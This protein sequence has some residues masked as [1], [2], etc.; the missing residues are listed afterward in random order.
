MLWFYKWRHKI[1]SENSRDQRLT[2]R[3][4]YVSHTPQWRWTNVTRYNDYGQIFTRTN[5][6]FPLLFLFQYYRLLLDYILGKKRYYFFLL[7]NWFS[8][9][10][11][12]WYSK[13]ENRI[14][15]ADSSLS[16][17]FDKIWVLNNYFSLQ[18]DYRSNS[19]FVLRFRLCTQFSIVEA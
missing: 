9:F 3:N 19:V 14:V 6:Y 15:V 18:C 16:I 5:W 17:R 8:S 2:Y 10:Q 4:N 12:A 11:G 7:W 13:Q 1:N